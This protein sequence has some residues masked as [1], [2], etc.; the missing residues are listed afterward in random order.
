MARGLNGE[1]GAARSGI[2]GDMIHRIRHPRTRRG[3]IAPRDVERHPRPAEK[4]RP[5]A[6]WN[7]AAGRWQVWSENHHAWVSLDDGSTQDPGSPSV[8][9]SPD[10]YRSR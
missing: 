2:V 10:W 1:G 7:E 4:P 5:D 6:Q 3:R 9:P 8:G